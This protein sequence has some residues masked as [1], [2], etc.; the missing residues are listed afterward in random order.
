MLGDQPALTSED[1]DLVVAAFDGRMDD[2]IDDFVAGRSVESGVFGRGYDE[3]LTA[4]T[5]DTGA[6]PLIG[7]W[8][9]CAS[10][11]SIG[12]FHPMSTPKRTTSALSGKPIPALLIGQRPSP[13]S[14]PKWVIAHRFVAFSWRTCPVAAQVIAV[15]DRY[16]LAIGRERRQSVDGSIG[17]MVVVAG[18]RRRERFFALLRMTVGQERR[19]DRPRNTPGGEANDAGI[20]HRVWMTGKPARARFDAA[21]ARTHAR[22]AAYRMIVPM[23]FSRQG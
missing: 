13:R 18:R 11:R 17:R 1:L 21:Q 2:D 20:Q 3:E 10:S 9:M 23:F 15:C 5:G 19:W 7:T 8:S 14:Q 16:R 6:R 4:L 22:C 12:L